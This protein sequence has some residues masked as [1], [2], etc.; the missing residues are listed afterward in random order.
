V[1]RRHGGELSR[2]E[3]VVFVIDEYD[4]YLREK[5]RDFEYHDI[6]GVAGR[7]AQCMEHRD[8]MER[9]FRDLA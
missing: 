2:I 9:T 4:R 6:G 3:N 8:V 5:L 1:L 7:F